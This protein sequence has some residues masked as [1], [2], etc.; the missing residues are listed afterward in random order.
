M[1]ISNLIFKLKIINI[2]FLELEDIPD[3]MKDKNIKSSALPVSK[4]FTFFI[5]FIKMWIFRWMYGLWVLRILSVYYVY[6][7]DV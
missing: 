5:E 3:Q 6:Q 2:L 4:N 7:N 1:L